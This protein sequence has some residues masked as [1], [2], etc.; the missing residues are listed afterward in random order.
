M[1][2]FILLLLVSCAK[3]PVS[4]STTNNSEF[5]VANLFEHEGCKVYRFSDNGDYHY[6]TNCP[7]QVEKNYSI[8]CGKSRCHKQEYIKTSN[9]SK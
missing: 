9:L 6:F 1:R 2:L 7:G 8:Q 3:D 4:K 5:E